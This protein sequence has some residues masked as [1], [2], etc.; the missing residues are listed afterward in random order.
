M[1]RK[2]FFIYGAQKALL[3]P[4]K[5]KGEH[6][7]KPT[8][9]RPAKWGRTQA[10]H[11]PQDWRGRQASTGGHGLPE[12]RLTVETTSETSAGEKTTA[13]IEFLE[14]LCMQL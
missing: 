5:S 13:A 2:G 11:C 14:V 8:L 9:P 10:N 7:E 12:Q 6:T 1:Q 3:C 4:T